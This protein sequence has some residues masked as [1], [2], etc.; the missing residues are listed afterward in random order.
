MTCNHLFFVFFSFPYRISKKTLKLI[1][2]NSF[3]KSGL[4]NHFVFF[5]FRTVSVKNIKVDT[6]KFC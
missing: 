4:K 1:L 5:H 3:K 2:A 6:L